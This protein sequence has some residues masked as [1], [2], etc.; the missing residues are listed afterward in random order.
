MGQ[1]YSKDVLFINMKL[2]GIRVIIDNLEMV[3][4]EATLNITMVEPAWAV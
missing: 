4:Q 3:T 2:V 1:Y